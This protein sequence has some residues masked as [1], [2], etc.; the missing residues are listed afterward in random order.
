M[1]AKK[2]LYFFIPTM[3]FIMA[4]LLFV[5]TGKSFADTVQPGGELD[6]LVT[7]SYVEQRINQALGGV[8]S[9]AD[10]DALAGEVWARIERLYGEQLVN[11]GL[12]VRSSDA[13]VPVSATA[14]QTILGHEGAE[15]ILRS[16]KA[17]AVCP[18]ENGLVNVSGGSELFHG[19]PVEQNNLLI[20]PRRDGRGVAASTDAWFLVKG[21]YELK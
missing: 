13:F 7:R 20:V 6:P 1:Q 2:P 10:M 15:I 18:G 17:T 19:K 9:D 16:G 14:G 8:S 5:F 21:G 4:I 11:A 3:F 12:P